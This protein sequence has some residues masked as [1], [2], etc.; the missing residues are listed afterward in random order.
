MQIIMCMTCTAYHVQNLWH[1][2]LL[3]A[4]GNE[5]FLMH[6]KH[7]KKKCV[8]NGEVKVKSSATEVSTA[9]NKI[10]D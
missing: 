1:A 3:G 10:S 8:H 6:G 5:L 9:A 4:R 2:K 7:K